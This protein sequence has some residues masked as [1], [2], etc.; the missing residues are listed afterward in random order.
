[1]THGNLEAQTLREAFQGQFNQQSLSED[2]LTAE[3]ICE[4]VAGQYASEKTMA[5]IN[6]TATCP[7]CAENWRLARELKHNFSDAPQALP[8][9]VKPFRLLP[10]SLAAAAM[11]IL[12][13]W[14]SLSREK[15]VDLGGESSVLRTGE[16]FTIESKLAKGMHLTR[17]ECVLQWSISSDGDV[18]EYRL[19][20]T[21]SDPF[22]VVADVV[23]EEPRYRIPA[24]ALQRL[25]AKTPLLWRVTATLPEVGQVHSPTFTNTLE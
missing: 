19:R 6:H 1:M 2:C 15:P 20:V 22:D 5:M 4:A 17:D 13:L 18:S 25:P 9:R 8:P 24:K 11:L 7:S 16:T 21:T 23:V 10:W 14:A 12:G 3:S